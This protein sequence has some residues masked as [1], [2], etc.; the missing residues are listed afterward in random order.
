M[1]KNDF[2][3]TVAHC[4]SEKESIV[5]RNVLTDFIIDTRVIASSFLRFILYK[6]RINY[7]Y[8][9]WLRGEEN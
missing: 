3:E 5:L 8:L 6:V 7:V 4:V 1:K 9:P 2:F